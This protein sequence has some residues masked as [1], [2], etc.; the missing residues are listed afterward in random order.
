MDIFLLAFVIF[1]LLFALA[2]A[3]AIVLVD[4]RFERRD[5]HI[6]LR[7]QTIAVQG[8]PRVTSNAN[9]SVATAADHPD[10]IHRSGESLPRGQ[11]VH[12]VNRV[13]A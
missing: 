5:T 9:E 4:R 6:A 13:T 1:S 11:A 10:K 3:A 7:R 8:N 12:Q 2:T